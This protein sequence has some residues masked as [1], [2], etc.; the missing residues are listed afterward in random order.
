MPVPA[1]FRPM[2]ACNAPS[3]EA[4]DYTDLWIQ[5]KIDAV[6]AI[7]FG[8]V[9]YSKSLTP[10]PNRHL[11]ATFGRPELEGFDGE[12]T[13]GSILDPLLFN[14]TTSAVMA[15][16][17]EH[18]WMLYAHDVFVERTPFNVR[19]DL[20]YAWAGVNPSWT[21]QVWTPEQIEAHYTA[22]IAGGYEGAMLRDGRMHYKFGRSTESEQALLKLKPFEDGE[23]I[24]VGFQELEINDNDQIKSNIGLAKRR[25]YGGLKRRADTLGAL[26]VRDCET[27]VRFS[28]G[29]GFT[30]AERKEIWENMPKYFK[31]IARYKKQKHGEL[32]APRIATFTGWRAELD[33]SKE[34]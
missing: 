15:E 32:N 12:L 31:R 16:G 24:V 27:G 7:V 25:S 11:Q 26:L 1:G 17:G 18:G 29:S 22:L 19:K 9:V 13:V 34:S 28:L 4:L 33:M 10:F 21:K 5:P 3:F 14:R 2:L 8:G 23:A 6:R 30:A 20:I